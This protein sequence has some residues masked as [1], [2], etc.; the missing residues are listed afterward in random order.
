[1]IN[2]HPNPVRDKILIDIDYPQPISFS[3]YSILGQLL[4]SVY[5]R[6]RSILVAD[7]PKGV[8]V[9]RIQLNDNSLAKEFVKE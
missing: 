4:K 8:Y 3:I 5:T 7:L 9:L 1:L 2:I 6:D